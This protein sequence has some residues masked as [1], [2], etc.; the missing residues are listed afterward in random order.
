V[1][2][3]LGLGV[4]QERKK[5]LRILAAWLAHGVV[6]AQKHKQLILGSG[7]GVIYWIYQPLTQI[8][9]RVSGP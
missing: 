8:L 2:I 9:L 1:L 5:T 6:Q 3:A 7:H 4:G